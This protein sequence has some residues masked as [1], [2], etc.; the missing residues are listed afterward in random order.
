MPPSVR[1]RDF[2]LSP[3]ESHRRRSLLLLVQLGIE[4][5]VAVHAAPGQFAAEGVAAR[6]VG[7]WHG[8][9]RRRE[10]AVVH[11]GAAV[12]RVRTRALRLAVAAHQLCNTREWAG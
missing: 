9:D 6:I 5:A 1:P 8:V 12:A 10:P 3:F 11:G 2:P 4:R 7:R